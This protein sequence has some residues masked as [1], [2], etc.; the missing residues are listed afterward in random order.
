MNWFWMRTKRCSEREPAD[1]FGNKSNIIG[2]W[3]PSLTSLGEVT[4]MTII[5][6]TFVA[7]QVIGPVLL[8]GCFQWRGILGAFALTAALHYGFH[9]IW[10]AHDSE[11]ATAYN[12]VAFSFAMAALGFVYCLIPGTSQ[13]LTSGESQVS[14]DGAYRTRKPSCI[15]SPSRAISK[16]T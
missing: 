15:V 6:T 12:A 13:R 9:R 7:A 1:L 16:G 3:P 8:I 10:V 14:C 11:A 5:L 2:G 4:L